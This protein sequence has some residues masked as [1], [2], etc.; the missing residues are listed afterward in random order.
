MDEHALSVELNQLEKKL[1]NKD[2][3]EPEHVLDQMIL[4]AAHREINI[5]QKRSALKSA[6]WRKILLPL[7]VATGFAFTFLPVMFLWQAPIFHAENDVKTP[8]RLQ[9]EQSET[10]LHAEKKHHGLSSIRA[11]E[12]ELPI[13]VEVPINT[14]RA[15]AEKVMANFD[16][17]T[18]Q[19]DNANVN[20]LQVFT[21]NELK[22]ALYPEKEAW[23]RKIMIFLQEDK[24]EQA[25]LEMIQFK[26]INPN[27]P[28]EEQIK[29]LIY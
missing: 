12:R 19:N 1:F 17:V 15:I 24:I 25:R 6:G 29:A 9:Y 14:D 28:I 18:I 8:F 23:V 3:R 16:L 7:Y 26:K 22:R 11:N 27:Y 4:S 13:R 21:G 10:E 2:E 20:K 5:P